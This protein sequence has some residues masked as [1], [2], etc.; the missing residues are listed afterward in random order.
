MVF[1]ELGQREGP[2]A[3]V[4][5]IY[6]KDWQSIDRYHAELKAK[7]EAEAGK[8]LP[9]MPWGGL[10]VRD[11]GKVKPRKKKEEDGGELTSGNERGTE[12]SSI[13]V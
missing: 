5:H 6:D 4:M 12:T 7:S 13:E 2:N 9:T 11:T 3:K 8:Y 10:P 1:L